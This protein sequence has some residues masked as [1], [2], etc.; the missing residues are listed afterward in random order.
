M[1]LLLQ[2]R[3]IQT[4]AC[5][6]TADSRVLATQGFG[7]NFDRTDKDYKQQFKDLS[8]RA[9]QDA[10]WSRI[11]LFLPRLIER[12]FIYIGWTFAIAVDISNLESEMSDALRHQIESLK[13]KGESEENEDTKLEYYF[14]RKHYQNIIEK[15]LSFWGI[16]HT[17]LIVALTPI[18]LFTMSFGLS[19]LLAKG[20]FPE[21]ASSNAG[22][23]LTHL[24]HGIAWMFTR[25]AQMT[26]PGLWLTLIAGVLLF[27]IPLREFLQP[28]SY[29]EMMS[30]IRRDVNLNQKNDVGDM[31]RDLFPTAR[32]FT[33]NRHAGESVWDA[34]FNGVQK[35]S[36]ESHP[37][38]ITAET[39]KSATNVFVWVISIFELI[40]LGLMR[41][42]EFADDT[43][44]GGRDSDDESEPLATVLKTGLHYAFIALEWPFKL[45]EPIGTLPYLAVRFILGT[46]LAI[47][48]A[49]SEIISL[50]ST[51]FLMT[52]G[53]ILSTGPKGV[54]E[55][56][57]NQW[58]NSLSLLKSY[59]RRLYASI[60]PEPDF[61]PTHDD[62]DSYTA[63]NA[64]SIL[65][66]SER[67]TLAQPKRGEKKQP[68]FIKHNP[69]YGWVFEE[70][71]PE[72]SSRYSSHTSYSML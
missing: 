53:V 26:L 38:A 20:V 67:T 42:A 23:L 72:Q 54:G 43:L 47:A 28:G 61:D 18:A 29:R 55:G 34:L 31:L 22:W 40:K 30:W 50:I 69:H 49:I 8:T 19:G 35:T 64:F 57:Q 9:K 17:I 15:H 7:E 6:A 5:M 63:L 46:A 68:W 56:L 21:L 44:L 33:T 1:H 65:T 48:G 62:Y 32:R 41:I 70:P 36:G 16:T 11:L 3:R 12:L 71:K 2:Q 24:Y 4:L 51:G 66:G 37:A 13:L 10:W 39:V 45:F 27:T 25:V 58:D 59:G 60:F 52:L 14:L